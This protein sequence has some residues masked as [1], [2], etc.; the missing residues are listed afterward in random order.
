MR[1]GVPRWFSLIGLL[2]AAARAQTAVAQAGAD[3]TSQPSAAANGSAP[4]GATDAE[5]LARYFQA[6]RDQ[7]LVASQTARVEE[8]RAMLARAE[9]LAQDG[10]YEDTALLLF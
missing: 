3:P 1:A 6:L 9:E 10:R 2:V 8:L 7:R 5:R 4:A